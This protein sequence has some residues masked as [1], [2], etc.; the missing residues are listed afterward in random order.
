MNTFQILGLSLAGL[1]IVLIVLGMARGKLA[2]RAGLGWLALWV[3]A[4]VFLANPE[5]TA[6]AARKVGN[7]RGADLIFYC[8]ILATLVSFFL[9]YV[10]L[11]R[12]ESNLTEIVRQL[13]IRDAERA[14]EADD[15]AGP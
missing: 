7:T 11:R 1:F 10:R 3:A 4:A 15:D 12:V 9:V 2:R 13:A 8:A 6:V 14:G 5:W